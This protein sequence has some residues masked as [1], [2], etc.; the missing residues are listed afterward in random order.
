MRLKESSFDTVSWYWDDK[1]F[2]GQ[3][4]A[5]HSHVLGR[6]RLISN[7]QLFPRHYHDYFEHAVVTVN[8]DKA[9]KQ[10]IQHPVRAPVE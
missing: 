9:Y 8:G 6:K 3:Q 7:F 5:H 2:N 4:R 10:T 1:S